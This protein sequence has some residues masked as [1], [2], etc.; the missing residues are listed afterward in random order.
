MLLLAS[1]LL[2]LSAIPAWARGGAAPDRASTGPEERLQ[3]LEKPSN[4][5]RWGQAKGSMRVDCGEPILSNTF[6]FPIC[7]S[8][9]PP[10]DVAA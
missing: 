2:W 7:A 10:L 8:L 3:L 5:G 6:G 9:E 4:L 1:L